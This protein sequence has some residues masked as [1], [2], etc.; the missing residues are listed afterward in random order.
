MK[1]VILMIAV[2]AAFAFGFY[3]MK[4]VDDFLYDNYKKIHSETENI[5]SSCVML[6]DNRYAK[7]IY[8]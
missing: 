5:E 7:A 1:D 4:C 3:I 8:W 6:T 2:L